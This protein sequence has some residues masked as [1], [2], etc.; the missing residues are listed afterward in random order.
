[1]PRP[2]V[3]TKRKSCTRCRPDAALP[4][5][6]EGTGDLSGVHVPKPSGAGGPRLRGSWV[7]V[8]WFS[9]LADAK[10]PGPSAAPNNPQRS[11][12]C[13]NEYLKRTSPAA[14]A[15]ATGASGCRLVPSGRVDL[16]R[17]PAPTPSGLLHR[18]ARRPEGGPRVRGLRGPDAPRRMVVHKPH[19]L[20]ERGDGGR[21]SQLPFTLLEVL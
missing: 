17:C 19:G 21:S 6:A 15:W 5:K 1:M 3:P 12:A 20:H 16:L 10:R 4:R 13:W 14:H 7:P 9:F 8:I 18:S 2:A 11:S